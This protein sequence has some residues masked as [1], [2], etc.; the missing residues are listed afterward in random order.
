MY[1]L[2]LQKQIKGDFNKNLFLRMRH[3]LNIE[4]G[5]FVSVSK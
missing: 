1:G 2:K 4:E 3:F 5:A